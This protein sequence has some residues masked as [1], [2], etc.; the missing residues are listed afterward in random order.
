[1]DEREPDVLELKARNL[2]RAEL[3]RRKAIDHNLNIYRD[4]DQ[5]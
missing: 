2:E 5:I 1:M 3:A 4:Q